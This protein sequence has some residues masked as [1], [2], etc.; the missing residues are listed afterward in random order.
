[1]PLFGTTALVFGGTAVGGAFWPLAMV[2]AT[3]RKKA[4]M[5][6]SNLLPLALAARKPLFLQRPM[7]ATSPLDRRLK[8]VPGILFL[9]FIYFLSLSCFLPHA[10]T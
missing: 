3:M 9:A 4:A 1:M 2:A 7:A 10:P 5:L 6:K 8:T